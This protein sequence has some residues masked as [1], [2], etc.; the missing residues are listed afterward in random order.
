MKVVTSGVVEIFKV[1]ELD[2]GTSMVQFSKT[3]GL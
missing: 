3:F 2:C 1:I